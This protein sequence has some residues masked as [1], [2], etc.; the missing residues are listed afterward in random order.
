M[1]TVIDKFQATIANHF[2]QLTLSVAYLSIGVGVINASPDNA[3]I[4]L[5]LD[6]DIKTERYF[7]RELILHNRPV[8]EGILE[9]YQ[10]KMTT[11]W[12]DLL[13]D[14][15]SSLMNLHFNGVRNFSELKKRNVRLD[16]S[17]ITTFHEQIEAALIADF[18]FQRYNDRVKIIDDILN[19]DSKH[20]TE[21]ANIKKHIFIRNAVQHHASK[22]YHD[23]LKELGCGGLALLD[24]NADAKDLG[25]DE[26]IVLSVPELDAIKRSLFLVSNEWRKNCG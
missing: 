17:S 20:K 11:A 13:N 7:L 9:L 10:N 4:E 25:V 2:R 5:S 3:S 22:V 24:K 8:E 12:S 23:M 14:L 21:L 26:Q 1:K 15:F 6:K 16:F 19:P 18:A